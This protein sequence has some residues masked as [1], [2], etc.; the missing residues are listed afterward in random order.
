MIGTSSSAKQNIIFAIRLLDIC[1]WVASCDT[2]FLL[3]AIQ[4]GG[5]GRRARR[6][7]GGKDERDEEEAWGRWKQFFLCD[8]IVQVHT[9]NNNSLAP[10]LVE[11]NL[12]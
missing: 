8:K 5:T 12:Y 10:D 1:H 3:H 4:G 6:G 2:Q 9:T 11:V 7:T